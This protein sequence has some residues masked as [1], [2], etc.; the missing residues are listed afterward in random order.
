MC[1]LIIG[2]WIITRPL[3]DYPPEVNRAELAY[4]GEFSDHHIAFQLGIWYIRVYADNSHGLPARYRYLIYKDLCGQFS[5][6]HSAFQL[7]MRYR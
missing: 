3:N 4:C 2:Y 7:G 5:D 6:H 1:L